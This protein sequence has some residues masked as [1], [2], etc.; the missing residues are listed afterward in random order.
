MWP[1]GEKPQ[2]PSRQA[3]DPAVRL[4]NERLLQLQTLFGKPDDVVG[5]AVVPFSMG[6]KH[7]GAADL[8]YFSNHIPGRLSVTAELIGCPEQKRNQLGNYELAIAHRDPKEEWGANLICRLAYYTLDAVVQ[9]GETMCLDAFAPQGS[10]INAL[11]FCDYGWFTL[12]GQSC[13]VLLCLGI[14]EPER[15]ACVEG[16]AAQVVKL[17]QDK[18]VYP[19]TDLTR[20]SVL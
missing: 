18:G 5:H 3:L 17:L 7:G 13:G 12:R 14:T 1:F 16:K 10:A 19:Y 9:P 11:L 4:W 15:L 2:K 6:P 20:K 8:V